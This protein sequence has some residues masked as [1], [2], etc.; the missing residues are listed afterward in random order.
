[1][2]TNYIRKRTS[3]KVFKEEKFPKYQELEG[4]QM[5]KTKT[6]D[7]PT[8]TEHAERWL[9]DHEDEINVIDYQ[10]R[11][12]W[13]GEQFVTIIYEEKYLRKRKKKE[14]PSCLFD[15]ITAILFASGVIGFFEYIFSLDLRTKWMMMPLS[16][17]WLIYVIGCTFHYI[18]I[19]RKKKRN[20]R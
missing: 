8:A 2:F 6:F 7:G 17:I 3:G 5:R 20:I 9:Q 12:T 19:E 14:K 10:I 13:Y 16:V 15:L 18:Y 1:V 11:P 4:K